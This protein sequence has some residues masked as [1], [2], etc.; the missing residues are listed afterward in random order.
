MKQTNKH[1]YEVN[2]KEWLPVIKENSQAVAEHPHRW[3]GAVVVGSL[4]PDLE[5]PASIV[6]TPG[7]LF[8]SGLP[9]AATISSREGPLY[10]VVLI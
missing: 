4:S 9:A 3:G 6:S 10:I 7:K 8:I 5:I 1:V 2:G